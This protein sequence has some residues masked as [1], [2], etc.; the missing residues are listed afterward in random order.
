MAFPPIFQPHDITRDAFKPSDGITRPNLDRREPGTWVNNTR[1]E[2]GTAHFAEA[3]QVDDLLLT[4][5]APSTGK[6]TLRVTPISGQFGAASADG[7]GPAEVSFTA[8]NDSFAAVVEGLIAAAD[9]SATVLTAAA[10]AAWLRL[11]SMV[12]LSVSPESTSKLR[13]TAT[14]SGATFVAE[15]ISATAGD[16]FTTTSITSP[17]TTTMKCGL[18]VALDRTQGTGGFTNGLPHIKQIDASTP[19]ADIFG[20]VYLGTNTEPVTG[21]YSFREYKP[22]NVPYARYGHINAY[23]ERSIAL[24]DG[25]EAVYVRHTANGDYI[26]GL[27]T[28]AAGAAAGATPNVWIGTVTS[29]NDTVFTQQIVYDGKTVNLTHLSA[30]AATVTTISNGLRADLLNYNGPGGP[31]EGLTGSGTTTLIITGPADGRSFTADSVGVGVIT[32]DE[33]TEAV[34]THKRLTR[35]DK[36]L[37]PSTRIGSVAV[38]VPITAAA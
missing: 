6:W 17:V 1:N 2:V 25:P 28:D 27:V 18:Y 3:V 19:V 35:G 31:L 7:I 21:G 15:L 32:W 20:P 14:A 11:R 23:G 13:V 22:G 24:A 26:P 5:T 34:S 29:A 33:D 8:D 9:A 12:N 38:D 16:S 10:S 36:F 30:G 37:T 4:G